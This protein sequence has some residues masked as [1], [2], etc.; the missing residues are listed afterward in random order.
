MKLAALAI[1]GA[2]AVVGAQEAAQTPGLSTVRTQTIEPP[3]ELAGHR[4]VDLDGDGSAELL[5]F[6]RDGRVRTLRPLRESPSASEAPEELTLDDPAHTLVDI[7]R[8]GPRA[9]LI[10]ATPRGVLAYATGDDKRLATTPTTLIARGKFTLRV[11]VPLQSSIVQDVNRDGVP[12]I[13]LP[14]VG[15]CELWLAH[16]VEGQPL[17]SFQR[18]ATIAVEVSRGGDQQAKYLSD[19]LEASFAI[20]NLDTRDVNG[21]GRP[22]LLV[23]QDM[24]RSFHLQR[25]D[26]SFPLQ[27]DVSVDLS[28][29]RDTTEDAGFEFG[30]TV[31]GGDRAT[32]EARDLDGDKI[33]DY[34]VAHGRKVWVFRASS[35]GPQFTEPSAIL[36]AADDV[37]AVLVMPLDDDALPELLLVKVQIP[38]LATLLRGLFGEWDV[39]IGVVGYR[40][41]GAGVFDTTPH[42]KNELTIRLPGII[43]VMKNPGKVLERVDALGKRFRTA[44]RGELNGDGARDVMIVTEDEKALEIWFGRAGESEADTSNER[45]VREML[46]DD[47]DK[48]WD[49]DR[50]LMAIGNFAQRRIALQTGGRAAEA[51]LTLR[52]PATDKLGSLEPADFDGDGRDEIVLA[53]D[54]RSGVRRTTFDVVRVT[55][56]AK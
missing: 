21:D 39:P 26:G 52:D 33:P 38:T 22:D 6:A 32:Y 24:R 51:S 41:E 17:P 34:V 35:A 15:G 53:Y 43:G 47:Q 40:N 1:L 55:T 12:D 30:G 37:T 50:V 31:S 3:F 28:I 4:I 2:W 46:F 18:A 29:F 44:E 56:G 36:K 8:L 27:P 49:I 42:W 16:A 54:R 10:A 5:V 9:S 20:P 14:G 19:R 25:A 23:E 48:V 45:R 13:V 11:G 7:A